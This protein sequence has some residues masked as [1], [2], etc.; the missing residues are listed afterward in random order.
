MLLLLT[1]CF[2]LCRVALCLII[3][4]RYEL[5]LIS[6]LFFFFCFFSL[7]FTT[8]TQSKRSARSA[9][10]LGISTQSV[11]IGLEK[12]NKSLVLVQINCERW[13]EYYTEKLFMKN[14]I[15]LRKRKQNWNA[16][17]Y[18]VCD[19]ISGFVVTTSEW[20][21]IQS[22]RLFNKCVCVCFKS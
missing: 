11:V 2:V 20:K 16:L 1:S 5:F 15:F 21:F 12:L 10:R 6:L 19:W 22:E 8:I 9:A 13:R 4:G 3:T 17:T 14:L 7:H 18:R